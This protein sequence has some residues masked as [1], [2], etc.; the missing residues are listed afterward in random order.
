MSTVKVKSSEHMKK[1]L[2][3]NEWVLVD[4]YATWCGPCKDIAPKLEELA[5]Q[6]AGKLVVLKVDIDEHE[7]I[8]EEFQI[9]AMPTFK[10]FKSGKVVDTM[11]GANH[12]KLVELAKKCEA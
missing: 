6:Y 10:L 2:N 11:M 7:D 3:D 9:T 1:N 5:A 8:T 4:F 12:A